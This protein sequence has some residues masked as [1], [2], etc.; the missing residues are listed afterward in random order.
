MRI[1]TSLVNSVRT[2]LKDSHGNFWNFPRAIVYIPPTS[3]NVS[4]E[5]LFGREESAGLAQAQRAEKLSKHV[6]R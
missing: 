5:I 1:G 2:E 4:G 3:L 6:H